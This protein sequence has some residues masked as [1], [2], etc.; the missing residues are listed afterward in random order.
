MSNLCYA[1]CA[2]QTLLRQ[3]GTLSVKRE[4]LLLKLGKDVADPQRLQPS[5]PKEVLRQECERALAEWSKRPAKPP[6]DEL[7]PWEDAR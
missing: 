6:V 5:P 2:R 7:P 3:R 4:K 1:R